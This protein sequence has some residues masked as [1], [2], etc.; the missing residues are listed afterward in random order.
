MIGVQI[1]RETLLSVVE[2]YILNSDFENIRT[3]FQMQP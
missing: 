3:H 2:T 1:L